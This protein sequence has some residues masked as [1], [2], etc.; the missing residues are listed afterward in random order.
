MLKFLLYDLFIRKNI[1]KTDTNDGIVKMKIGFIGTGKIAYS[2]IIALVGRGHTITI[3]ER[4]KS[5]STRLASEFDDVKIASPQGVIDESDVIFLAIMEDVTETILN[6]ITFNK[7]QT[8]ISFILGVDLKR[9]Q[10]LCSP[11]HDIA[12]TIPLPMIEQGNCPLPIYPRNKALSQLFGKE[13]FIMELSSEAELLPFFAAT[14]ILSTSLAQ[15]E[16]AKKWLQKHLDSSEVAESYLVNLMAGTYS[17]IKKDG[18]NRIA[19][20]LNSLST[21]GGLNSQLLNH[22]RDEGVEDTLYNGLSSL[23]K[24]LKLN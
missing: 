19:E 23:G 16:I 15:L 21:K 5:I 24:R 6:S 14:A 11:A 12:I 9:L 13:N 22:M 17:G 8:I 2:C 7:N 4:N 20:E 18:V 1:L 10:T 3:T